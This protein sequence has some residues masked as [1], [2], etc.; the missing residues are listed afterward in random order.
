[1]VS[2]SFGRKNLQKGVK[3]G[4]CTV[5][6]SYIARMLNCGTIGKKYLLD[7]LAFGF[8]LFSFLV[9]SL[10]SCISPPKSSSRSFTGNYRAR[11]AGCSPQELT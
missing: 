9:H 6:A 11:V 8:F 2:G 1:M 3:Y 7:S 10:I 4:I 5:F